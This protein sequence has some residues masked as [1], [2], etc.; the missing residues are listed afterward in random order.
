M[1]MGIEGGAGVFP[2]LLLLLP[3]LLPVSSARYSRWASTILSTVYRCSRV[4]PPE[5]TWRGKVL[6]SVSEVSIARVKRLGRF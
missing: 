2:T 6:Q 4:K 3:L 1:E 5:E